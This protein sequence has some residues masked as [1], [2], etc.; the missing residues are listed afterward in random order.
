MHV[1]VAGGG[2]VGTQIAQLLAASNNDVV[3]VESDRTTASALSAQGLTVVAGDACQA[4]VL[5]AAGGLRTDVLVACTGSDEENLVVSVL[6]KHHLEIPRV[7]SRVNLE[8]NRWLFD[9]T[10]GV[11]AA[12]SS[13]STLVALIE[14]ATGSAQTLR[15]ADLTAAGLT[16]IEVNVTAGSTALGRAPDQLAL[17]KNDVVAAVIRCGQAL[18]ADGDLHLADGDGVLVITRPDDEASVRSAFYPAG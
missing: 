18:I 11:D 1:I 16:I 4:D 2:D 3:V 8:A 7:V 10:W 5:E 6:A 9:A 17:G 15:L 14:E 13:V 12:V